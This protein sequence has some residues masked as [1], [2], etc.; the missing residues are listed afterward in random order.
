MTAT[1]PLTPRGF[2]RLH[3][4]LPTV[5]AWFLFAIG[6]HLNADAQEGNS[7]N[8]GMRRFTLTVVGPDGESIPNATIEVRNG[9]RISEWSVHAGS[10]KKK[11]A[12]GTLFHADQEGR[13]A[14]DLP[15][16]KPGRLAIRIVTKGYGPFWAQW[17]NAQRSETLP[18]KYTARLDKGRS[19]GGIVVDERGQPIEG[20][21]IHPSIEYKKREGDLSQLG[22]GLRLVTDAKGRWRFDSVPASKDRLGVS[23]RHPEYMRKAT[24]LNTDEFALGEDGQPTAKTTIQRGITV[25]G[26]ITDESGAPIAG[27]VVRTK[28]VN[29]QREVKTRKGGV[30]QLLGCE[31]VRTSLVVTAAGRAPELREVAIERDMPSVDFKLKPGKTIR[32]RVLDAAGRPLPRTRIFFQSW[33]GDSHRYELGTIHE[34]TDKNG[35]WEWKEAPS[36]AVIC[37]ICPPGGMTLGR[38]TLIA[39]DEEYVFRPPPAL[40]ISGR[41]IDAETKMPVKEFRVV[42]GWRARE[43]HLSWSEDESFGS[44]NGAYRLKHQHPRFAF[45]IKIEADGYL[46]A[47]SRDIKADEGNVTINVELKK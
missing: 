45:L 15:K 41:V 33:R 16:E 32:I 5:C 43:S 7:P 31:P 37:D 12:Y 42:P 40:V 28:F 1:R 20:A 27:A 39:R 34:Y 26:T 3:A 46:P 21:V 36:D 23:I 25:T 2:L 38:E 47:T 24:A 6:A 9:L 17:N 44:K 22:V 35:I 10:F 29:D 30:Y 11:L 4:A 19:V 18:E 14:F 8:S 13:F